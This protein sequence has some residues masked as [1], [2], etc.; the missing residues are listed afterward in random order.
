MT[1]PERTCVSLPL[2][3]CLGEP[4][5]ARAIKLLQWL[6]GPRTGLSRCRDD[7]SP[8][9]PQAPDDGAHFP[10]QTVPTHRPTRALYSGQGDGV[11]TQE[12]LRKTLASKFT[13]SRCEV[14]LEV[15]II[16]LVTAS[17]LSTLSH[18]WLS[19][20]PCPQLNPVLEW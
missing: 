17:P 12:N 18:S 19:L 6:E 13:C 11:T 5:W 15:S 8:G 14:I 4:L 9:R 3:L 16:S 7:R 1:I 10:H 2:A 20:L